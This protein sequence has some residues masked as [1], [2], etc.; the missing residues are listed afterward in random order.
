M[1]GFAQNR[2]E[3]AAGTGSKPG[4]GHD[5]NTALSRPPAILPPHAGRLDA[6]V[7]GRCLPTRSIE[8]PSR[9]RHKAGGSGDRGGVTMELPMS[10]TETSPAIGLRRLVELSPH[11]EAIA[12][13][14]ALAAISQPRELVTTERCLDAVTLRPRAETVLHSTPPADRMLRAEIA[15]VE[16]LEAEDALPDEVE[17][18]IGEA[19]VLLQVPRGVN[20]RALVEAATITIRAP[21]SLVAA[22]LRQAVTSQKFMPSIGELLAE[23]E[24]Q[25]RE[26]IKLHGQITHALLARMVAADLIGGCLGDVGYLIQTGDLPEGF[27]R[28]Q[29]DDDSLPPF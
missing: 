6:P 11:V 20:R 14:G 23:I 10:K 17:A 19:L 13:I 3:E 4:T 21:R 12:A 28:M 26:A 15:I 22:A 1:S 18:D 29:V 9:P 5:I 25:R 8:P 2:L 7:C 24:E 27:D 16:A